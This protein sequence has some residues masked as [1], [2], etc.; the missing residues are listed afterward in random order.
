MKSKETLCDR[1]YGSGD[2]PDGDPCFACSGNGYETF[3]DTR[4]RGNPKTL[5]Y[6]AFANV[7]WCRCDQSTG[8]NARCL[9]HKPIEPLHCP[10]L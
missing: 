7:T 1:C 9:I 2:G 5:A 3:V 4:P 8:D 10:L 6:K